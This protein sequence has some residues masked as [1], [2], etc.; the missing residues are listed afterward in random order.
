M[1]GVSFATRLVEFLK[2]NKN[3]SVRD[4]ITVGANPDQSKH[5]ETARM[6]LWGIELDLV[7]LR[8]E[9]YA[10]AS[11]IPNQIVCT[12]PCNLPPPSPLIHSDKQSFGTPLVDALR[13]DITI[14]SLFYN[15]HSRSIEDFT[16]K[17]TFTPP[18]L[19][20]HIPNA[21]LGPKRSP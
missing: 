5:L 2:S 15:V 11:R 7:N 6:K 12:I 21:T 1:T 4:P 17:V 16:D 18:K 10:E 8:A 20:H 9:E 3:E 14:N 13:R 19:P